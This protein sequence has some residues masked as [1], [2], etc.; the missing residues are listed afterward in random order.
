MHHLAMAYQFVGRLPD[1][2]A[3]LEQILEQYKA[4]LGPNHPLT[5]IALNCLGEAYRKARELNKAAQLVEQALK[6]RGRL[7]DPNAPYSMHDLGLIYRD[8]GRYD[9]AIDLLEGATKKLKVMCGASHPDTLYSMENLAKLYEKVEKFDQADRMIRELI[10]A[11][12]KEELRRIEA[13]T[14]HRVALSQKLLS[15]NKTAEAEAILRES[16]AVYVKAKASELKR[17]RGA[18]LL[19]ETLLEQNQFAAAEPLLLQG[20]EGMKRLETSIPA[21][22][23]NWL[24]AAGQLVVRFY[25][26]TDQPEKAREWQEKVAADKP[27]H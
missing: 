27:P 17:F 10:S 12:R 20:Y 6:L 16:L 1:A 2:I 4:T 11:W 5:L 3:L 13:F 19:G 9:E 21:P 22:Q 26:V 8:M 15:Q 25:E 14:D 18:S 24:I 23:S 7:D